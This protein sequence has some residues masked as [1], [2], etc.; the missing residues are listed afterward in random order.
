MWTVLWQVLF[1]H[2]CNQQYKNMTPSFA[3]QEA[4][5]QSL[6]EGCSW[7]GANS[8]AFMTCFLHVARVSFGGQWKCSGKDMQMLALGTGKGG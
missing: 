1:V 8:L 2:V 6:L 4:R 5:E 3:I 7:L